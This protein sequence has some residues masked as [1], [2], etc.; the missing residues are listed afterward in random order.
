M[1]VFLDFFVY[2]TRT[3]AYYDYQAPIYNYK[4]GSLDSPINLSHCKA[5][6]NNYNVGGGKNIKDV[7]LKATSDNEY[8]KLKKYQPQISNNA[9]IV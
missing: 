2:L 7:D 1:P 3:D 6:S 5:W 9:Y 8:Y 4:I